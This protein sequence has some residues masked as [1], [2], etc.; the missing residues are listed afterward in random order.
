MKGYS[1]VCRSKKQPETTYFMSRSMFINNKKDNIDGLASI[2]I[3][4]HF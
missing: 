4:S 2:Y 3:F 1:Q